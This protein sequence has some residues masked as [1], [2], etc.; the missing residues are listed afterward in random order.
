MARFR[1]ERLA[2]RIREIISDVIARDLSDPRVSTLTTINRVELSKDMLQARVYISV[3]GG[4]SREGMTLQAMQHARGFIQKAVAR[5]LTV[6]QCPHI[7]IL[8]DEGTRKARETFR[9]LDEVR[10]PFEE[11]DEGAEGTQAME[12]DR[13]DAPTRPGDSSEDP[14]V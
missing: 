1:K 14:S 11:A 6:R 4:T 13:L 8:L 3:F 7:E 12:A 9:L 5:G 2:S 10:P